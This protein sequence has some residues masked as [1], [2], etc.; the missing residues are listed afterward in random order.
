M[1]RWEGLGKS[2]R[3]GKNSFTGWHSNGS[4][5]NTYQR[6]GIDKIHIFSV[7]IPQK[8]ENLRMC[9]VSDAREKSLP[10]ALVVDISAHFDIW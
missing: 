8:K 10:L 7:S 3:Q 1:P 9:K 4:R 2:S 5:Y 6:M